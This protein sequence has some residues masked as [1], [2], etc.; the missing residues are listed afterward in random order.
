MKVIGKTLQYMVIAVG[1]LYFLIAFI[2]WKLNIASIAGTWPPEGRAFIGI[3]FIALCVLCYAAV[4]NKW[5][6]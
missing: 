6:D 3:V 5:F 2:S 1:T 4:K